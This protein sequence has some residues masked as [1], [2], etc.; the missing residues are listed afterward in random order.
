MLKFRNVLTDKT[1]F[2]MLNQIESIDIDTQI[3]FEMAEYFF[4]KYRKK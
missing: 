2:I 1:K 4:K 3:E